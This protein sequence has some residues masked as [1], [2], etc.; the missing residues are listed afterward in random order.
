M[1]SEAGVG[2]E[3]VVLLPLADGDEFLTP[4]AGADSL[5]ERLVPLVRKPVVEFAGAE[6]LAEADGSDLDASSS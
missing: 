3:F 1:A 4:D 5:M 6:R 2:S